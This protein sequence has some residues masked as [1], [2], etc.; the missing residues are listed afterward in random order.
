M[1]TKYIIRKIIILLA[2]SIFSSSIVYA[3]HTHAIDDVFFACKTCHLDNQESYKLA[4]VSIA[5]YQLA[6][7]DYCLYSLTDIH[8]APTSNQHN[9]SPPLF[10]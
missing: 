7:T 9:K 1:L 2:L 8:L 6:D 4:G 10:A 5:V 3:A